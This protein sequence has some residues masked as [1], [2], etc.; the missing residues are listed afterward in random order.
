MEI[1]N[2]DVDEKKK[3]MIKLAKDKEFRRKFSF[4]YPAM[5]IFN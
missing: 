1:F 3:L 4:K 5:I 2:F